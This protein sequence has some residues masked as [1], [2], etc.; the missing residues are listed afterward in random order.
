[1][2]EV[3]CLMKIHEQGNIVKL[4]EICL[5]KYFLDKKYHWQLAKTKKNA[6][7]VVRYETQAGGAKA[8]NFA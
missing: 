8:T 6:K 2:G 3:W 1:M 4:G 7:H 5:F